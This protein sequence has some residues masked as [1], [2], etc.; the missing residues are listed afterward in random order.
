MKRTLGGYEVW[1]TAISHA[2]PENTLKMHDLV[3]PVTWYV[4]DG[5]G[6]EYARIGGSPVVEAG[7]LCESRNAALEDGFGYGL[8]VVELSDDLRKI[9][10]TTGNA[11][12]DVSPCSFE[13]AVKLMLDTMTS[14]G[15]RLGGVA[16]TSNHFYFNPKRPVKQAHF[17]VGD[18]IVIRPSHERFDERLKLKEDYDFTLQHIVSHGC[19]ARCDAILATFLHRGNKGGAVDFRTPQ[20]EQ[21]AISL[22]QEKWPG[23]FHENP[24]RPNEIVMSLR[25]A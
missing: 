2:R 23:C 4:G 17:I 20:R 3:G 6:D 16:P 25:R 18:F 8:P 15:A 9:Q 12:G 21:D 1:V 14:R 11:K 5:E 24:R 7:G 10:I 13:Q 19:V 22:L